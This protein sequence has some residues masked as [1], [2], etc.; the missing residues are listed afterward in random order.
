ML[1]RSKLACFQIVFFY[2]FS[3]FTSFILFTA[4]LYCWATRVSCGVKIFNERF[5]RPTV[6]LNNKKKYNKLRK[7][8]ENF[9]LNL[10]DEGKKEVFNGCINKCKAI[11][12]WFNS[13]IW[14]FFCSNFSTDCYC[15]LFVR[16]NFE[17]HLVYW[18]RRW[19]W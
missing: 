7:K 15:Y 12:R 18:S 5:L 4:F 14:L 3:L 13:F 16:F 1:L 2:I 6:L 10:N 9:E 19:C 11:C 17:W 8:S